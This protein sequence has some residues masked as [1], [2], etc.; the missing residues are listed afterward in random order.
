MKKFATV[1]VLLTV[2]LV[3]L[4]S[5]SYADTGINSAS[6]TPTVTN[7]GT[8]SMIP[9]IPPQ[10]TAPVQPYGPPPPPTK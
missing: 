8:F 9:V 5:V 10:P 2:L 6:V 1:L 4:C 3:A 7:P